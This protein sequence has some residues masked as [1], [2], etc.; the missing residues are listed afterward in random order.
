MTAATTKPQVPHRKRWTKREYNQAVERGW[1]SGSRIHLYRGELIEMPAMGHLHAKSVTRITRLLY[2]LFPEPYAV[3]IQMPL[4]VPGESMPEP[5]AAICTEAQ[6]KRFPHPDRAELVI[7][8]ADT[9][10]AY[11]R[12][13][14]LDYAAAGVQDYWIVDVNARCVELFREPKADASS[15]TGHRYSDTRTLREGETV[16]PLAKPDASI[17]IAELLP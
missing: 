4:E 1:F 9:S 5:D 13:K 12:Q 15:D 2:D 16:S 11:D 17:A 14:A 10:L 3:R 6:S 8:V 7:E